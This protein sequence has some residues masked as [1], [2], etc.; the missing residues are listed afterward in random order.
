MCCG[1]K[2]VAKSYKVKQSELES[3]FVIMQSFFQT[4]DSN[5]FLFECGLVPTVRNLVLQ[6]LV[7]LEKSWVLMH[8]TSWCLHK[9]KEIQFGSCNKSMRLMP[10]RVLLV[11]WPGV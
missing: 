1:E 3:K 7:K 5:Q 10:H 4:T 2:S 6:S 11:S 9:S 8:P